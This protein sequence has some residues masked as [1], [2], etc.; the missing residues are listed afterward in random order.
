MT[1]RGSPP[2]SVDGADAG[3]F[4][5]ELEKALEQYTWTVGGKPSLAVFDEPRGDPSFFFGLLSISRSVYHEVLL[6]TQERVSL[7][8]VLGYES[9]GTAMTGEELIHCP[10]LE[11]CELVDGVVV[12]LPLTRV[13]EGA[14]KADLGAELCI[15]IEST[16]RGYGFLGNVGVYI[17]RNPDTVRAADLIY[18]SNER[19]ARQGTSEYLDIAPE[20]IIE[21]LSPD[22]RWS[23]VMARLDDYLSVGVDRVWLVDSKGS[24]IFVYHSLNEV[25]HYQV[26][27]ILTDEGLLPGFHLAVANLLTCNLGQR[28]VCRPIRER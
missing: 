3:C 2:P 28:E 25:Q 21:V 11:L 9:E 15:W 7:T 5:I 1:R 22:E 17:R 18:V 24:R 13:R 23:E 27:D 16:G 12:P 8:V 10:N 14:I 4:I 6:A 26:G 19:Y 20:L